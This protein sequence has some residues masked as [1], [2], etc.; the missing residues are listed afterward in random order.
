M[1]ELLN[2]LET[3]PLDTPEAVRTNRAVRHAIERILTQLV[4]YAVAINQH[5]AAAVLGESPTNYRDSFEAAAQCGLLDR[6]LAKSLMP[7]VGLRNVLVHEYLEVD[8]D[9]VVA[10]VPMARDGYR[11]YVAAAAAFAAQLD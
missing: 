4:E 11:R 7:S 10:A 9:L 3:P 5:V 1:R 6:N 2:D 8:L